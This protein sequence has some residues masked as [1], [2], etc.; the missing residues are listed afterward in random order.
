MHVVNDSAINTQVHI[1][2]SFLDA[3]LQIQKSHKHK[4][5]RKKLVDNFDKHMKQYGSK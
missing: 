1:G 4:D 5:Y 3:I 2:M